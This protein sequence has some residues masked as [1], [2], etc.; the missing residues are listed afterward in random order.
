MTLRSL[1]IAACL[2]CSTAAS[3]APIS[4]DFDSLSPPVSLDTQFAGLGVVFSVASVTNQTFGGQV[5]VPSG[6]NYVAFGDGF[7]ITFVDP[8]DI[9]TAAVTDAVSIANLG[10]GSL[11]QY[12]GY[13]VSVRNLSGV[14]IGTATVLPV[15]QGSSISPYDTS[16]EIAGIHSLL[17]TRLTNPNG[18]GIVGIDSLRFEPVTA[19]P[20][21]AALWLF[22]P[23]V[24]GLAG[25][26][27]RAS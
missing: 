15:N 19:V 14:E 17:F 11:G 9:T 7:S 5:I 8:N 20:V 26:R 3:A 2:A 12:D 24:A 16:F 6:S 18:A 23:V 4:V 21:P 27:R 22:A 25:M 10:I 1:F 13:T